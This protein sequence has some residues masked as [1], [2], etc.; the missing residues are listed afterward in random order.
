MQKFHGNRNT[1]SDRS[2]KSKVDEEISKKSS[3]CSSKSK[4][5]QLWD[6]TAEKNDDYT[7]I[8]NFEILKS[9]LIQ[10]YVH[11]VVKNYS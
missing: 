7:I 2:K 3:D 9:F 10:F 5:H 11:S 1:V 8:I 6:E 4:I